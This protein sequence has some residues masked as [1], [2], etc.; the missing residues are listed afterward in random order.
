MISSEQHRS[1]NFWKRQ[2]NDGKLK[3][4]VRL[5]SGGFQDDLP[6]LIVTKGDKKT[7][8]NNT[9]QHNSDAIH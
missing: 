1:A 2:L 9:I 3:P 7:D 6:K 5:A 8:T 4:I